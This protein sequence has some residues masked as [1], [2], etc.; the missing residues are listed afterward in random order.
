ML[1]APESIPDPF[2]L[3]AGELQG[4]MNPGL[5]LLPELETA[6]LNPV[7]LARTPQGQACLLRTLPSLKGWETIPNTT[8]TQYHQFQRSGERPPYQDPYF[9][10]RGRVAA[11]ALRM[12]FGEQ[13]Y[14]DALQDH[15]WSICEETDW[16]VPAHEQWSTIDLM[17]AETGLLLAETLALVGG[18]LEVEI[19]ERV[20]SEVRRRILNPYLRMYNLHWWYTHPNNWSGVCN[21]CIAATFLWLEPDAGR[22]AQALAIALRGLKS[23]C[24]TA[25]EPDG[26]STE[27]VGYWQYGLVYFVNLAEML[28]ACMNGAID[29]LAGYRMRQIAA[30]PAGMYLGNGRFIPF[31]DCDELVLME[32]GMLNRLSERSGVDSLRGL[33]LPPQERQG[34]HHSGEHPHFRLPVLLRNLLWWDGSHPQGAVMGSAFFPDSGIARLSARLPDGERVILAIKAGHNAEAH[35]HNDIGSFVLATC[36]EIFLTDPGTGLYSRQY[37]NEE[38]YQNIFASSFGHSLPRFNGIL[39]QAG[40]EFDGKICSIELAGPVQR[41]EIE[42]GRAYP[43][44]QLL[45]ARR[46]L[47]LNQDGSTRLEDLFQFSQPDAAV[48]EAFV[49]WLP[50]VIENNAARLD[51][52]HRSLLLT[53]ES[54]TGVT[55]QTQR[56]EDECKANAKTGVLTRLSFSMPA[57]TVSK[58]KIQMQFLAV[59]E[60]KPVEQDKST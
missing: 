37:F 22:T 40:R 59:Q 31:S 9:L 60:R 10:K 48:E 38:R 2:A 26:S 18:Q 3:T 6:R 58:V 4:L 42:F 29:L 17:A 50:V 25:F 27:G 39:Q 7:A 15:L 54:P 12:F 34:H 41:V 36:G 45:S 35:N 5:S 49:T 53:V 55:W 32:P 57:G 13:G 21:S 20:C 33:I 44:P 14:R 46:V 8:Y 16:V 52:S 28:R 23:F 56:L 24:E 30:Y 1:E 19:R 11:F 43:V 51:G 47:H